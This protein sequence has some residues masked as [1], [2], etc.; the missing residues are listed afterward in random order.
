MAFVKASKK[1]SKLRLAIT[2]PS[3]S[4][5][6]YGALLIA[7]GIGGKIACIDTER[8]SASLYE[9]IVDFDVQELSPPFSPESFVRAIKEA[10]SAGYDVLIIDSATHEWNGSGGALEI[11]EQVGRSK[12]RGNTQAAWSEVT[13]RHQAFIDA[14]LQSNMH[15]IATSRSKTETAQA[16]K[17]GRKVLTKLGMK[18]EQRPGFEYEFGVVLDL[19][20]DGHYATASKDRTETEHN[21]A[22]FSGDPMPITEE[23]GRKL[24]AWLND[25]DEVPVENQ[26]ITAIKKAETIDELKDAYVQGVKSANGDNNLTSQL[27]Q[28]KDVR[29]SQLSKVDVKS[30][31][32]II[33]DAI[34]E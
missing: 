7:K 28:A 22:L 29:K 8:G 9:H 21:C 27:T 10:E 3:G 25:G 16:E 30:P 19:I 5:K 14:M 2:G 32:Q 17:D 15:I 23:T 20:H 33:S 18:N 4:G 12:F 26:L 34:G 6:T 13:P 1:K 24:L 11:A 31:E